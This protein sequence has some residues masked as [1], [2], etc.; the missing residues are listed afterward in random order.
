MQTWMHAHCPVSCSEFDLRSSDIRPA[1][2][3]QWTSVV[4]PLYTPQKQ[5][6]SSSMLSLAHRVRPRAPKQ[7]RNLIDN[8]S[9]CARTGSSMSR[10]FVTTAPIW[11]T[12]QIMGKT[13]ESFDY[14]LTFCRLCLTL[15]ATR[16]VSAPLI[17]FRI[18]SLKQKRDAVNTKYRGE[19]FAT[20]CPVIISILIT[21]S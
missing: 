20:A 12:T 4:V 13:I 19:H 15:A 5:T 16:E 14:S 1:G 8:V 18:T 17:S 10:R 9:R 21:L 3:R 6:Q 7:A 11:K 2:S